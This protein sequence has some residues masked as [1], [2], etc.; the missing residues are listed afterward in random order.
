M[1]RLQA[2]IGQRQRVAAG[3]LAEHRGVEVPGRIERR[4]ARPDDVPRPEHRRRKAGHPRLRQ[5]PALDFGLLRPVAASAI[6]RLVL[7]G[8][9]RGVLGIDPD[10]AA[11][12]KMLATLPRSASTSCC[13]LASVKLIM[14]MT[15]S[16][17]SA[18]MRWPKR[19]AASSAS[20]SACTGST[21]S[22]AACGGEGLPRAAA[23]IGPPGARRDQPRHQIRPDMPA[24]ADDHHTRHVR[25]PLRRANGNANF[26]DC[27]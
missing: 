18:A 5:L 19:P 22:Q 9:H 10:R 25:P 15:M 11:M 7:G 6:E 1:H 21:R 24:A 17:S 14:S 3:D 23:D 8:R 16:G 12:E 26:R 20:R 27:R 13:V 4:P 2:E